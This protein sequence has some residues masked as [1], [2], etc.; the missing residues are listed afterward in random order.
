[1]R[2]LD[3]AILARLLLRDDAAQFEIA[4]Q[5][6][7]EPFWIAQTVLLELGWVLFKAV[8]LSRDV[9]ASLLEQLLA[10]ESA[11][12]ESAEGFVWALSR[13]REGADWADMVHLVASAGQAAGF[14]TL[15]RKLGKQAGPRTPLP[16]ELF[17]S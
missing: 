12:V 13:F 10:L 7:G 14:A 6:V 4:K 16:V 2:S 5:L 8:G 3:T 17:E 9:V 1:L 15:D 11:H